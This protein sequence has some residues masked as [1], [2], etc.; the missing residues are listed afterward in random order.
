VASVVIGDDDGDGG[1]VVE[2]WWP[3]VARGGSEKGN[4]NRNYKKSW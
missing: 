4:L 3:Y 2:W 1:V